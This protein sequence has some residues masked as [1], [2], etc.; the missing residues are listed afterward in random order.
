MKKLIFLSAVILYFPI[1][2]MKDCSDVQST[3]T[4]SDELANES[5][6]AV[7]FSTHLSPLSKE[8]CDHVIS[9]APETA[10]KHARLLMNPKTRT[11]LMPDLVILHGPTG[12]GKSLL[13]RVIL[14]ES[15]SPFLIEKAGMLGN[16]FA[17]SRAAGIKRIGKMIAAIKGNLMVDEMDRLTTKKQKQNGQDKESEDDAPEAFWQLLDDME[18][19]KRLFIGTSNCLEN[20]PTPLQG[21]FETHLFCVPVVLNLPKITEKIV[22]FHLNGKNL[23]SQNVALDL[24]K[25]V[26]GLSNR[27]ISKIIKYSYVLALERNENSPI[28]TG[29][30]IIESL[31]KLSKDK[32]FLAKTRWDKKEVFNYTVQTISAIANVAS[33]INMVLSLSNTYHSLRLTEM[34]L[35]NQI[36]SMNLQCQGLGCQ[37]A[38]LSLQEKGTDVQEQALKLQ[39]RGIELQEKALNI[40][41]NG[42]SA[43]KEGLNLQAQALATQNKALSYQKWTSNPLAFTFA[44][45]GKV[46]GA[47]KWVFG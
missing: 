14:Q 41:E 38:A 31:N 47:L 3:Y 36:D 28:I 6:G 20:M 29:K 18:R 24:C 12:S 15:G 21:R 35:Q 1:Y 8:S 34:G 7:T 26:N 5:F 46:W 22:Q 30:D 19:D 4:T 10:Q 27:Q 42:L 16:A 11:A 23:E 32:K 44:T 13:G 17:N 43:Q 9:C 37:V 33:I 45:I 2:S 39:Q 40:Q 25:K